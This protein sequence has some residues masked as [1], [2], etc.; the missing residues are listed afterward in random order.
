LSTVYPQG[1]RCAIRMSCGGTPNTSRSSTRRR[2]FSD[3][4]MLLDDF[5]RHIDGCAPRWMP[6]RKWTSEGGCLVIPVILRPCDWHDMPFGRL[7]A[8]PKDGKAI[9]LWPNIDEASLT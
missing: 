1:I 5:R 8:T 4:S 3:H 6:V 2:V 9:T 7:Q